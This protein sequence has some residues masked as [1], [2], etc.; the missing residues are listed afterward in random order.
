MKNIKIAL[1]T[2]IFVLTTNSCTS[3]SKDSSNI[4]ESIKPTAF[5]EKLSS[6]SNSYL[7]DVRTPE[8]FASG[9]LKNALNIDWNN[10]NFDTEV[11]KL[12]KENPVFI[13]CLSGGRSNQAANK[14]KELGFK[15]IYELEGG[16]LQWRNA[17]LPEEK[18]STKQDLITPEKFDSL[19]QE[20]PLVL[21]DY[22]ANW[23][24]PCMKMKPFLEEISKDNSNDVSVVRLNI[25]ESPNISKSH[26]VSSLPVLHLYK[27]KSLV[28][29]NKGYMD[30]E[31]ILEVLKKYKD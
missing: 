30:K 4:I 12:D 18:S 27:N 3:N 20:K 13:Y 21:I 23:C 10:E 15:T 19:L 9:F 31:A 2:L 28:W 7:L 24:A 16:I 11:S 1:F 25:E 8:E 26:G 17:G 22:Y 5:A 14:L 29:S 6:T